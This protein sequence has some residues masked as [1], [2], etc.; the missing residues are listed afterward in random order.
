MSSQGPGT[1][2]PRL[3]GQEKK[4]LGLPEST[5]K[6]IAGAAVVVAAVVGIV[7]YTGKDKDVEHHSKGVKG[8]LEKKGQEIKDAWK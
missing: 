1:N 7:K 3:P 2:K 5:V 6:A 4:I 8:K